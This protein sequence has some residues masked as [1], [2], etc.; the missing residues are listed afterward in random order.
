MTDRP[1]RG[2]WGL[3]L[4]P[5]AIVLFLLFVVPLAMLATFSFGT[6]DVLGRPELGFSLDNYEQVVQGYNLEVVARTVLYAASATAICLVMGYAVAYTAARFGGRWSVLLVAL[7]V[8]PWL[9]SYVVRIYAWKQLLGD[10]G[11]VNGGLT[12]V[13][14]GPVGWIGTPYAVV[15]GLVYSY[16]PL[17]ILPLYAS[18]KD[19]DPALIDA[20][21]DLFGSPRKTFWFVT[22]PSTR[23]GVVGGC[24]LVFLPALGDFATAQF[25][26]G[27]QTT[28]VG[29]IVA[30]QFVASGQQTFGAAL[31]MGLV[32]MLVLTVL[33][34]SLL[35]RRRRGGL[36]DVT[37]AG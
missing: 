4:A 1:G 26:G 12:W 31:S 21:K 14:L 34:A 7:V 5:S 19:L 8:V 18:L 37:V 16:L 27:A 30:D 23:T 20:G 24:M 32:V 33:T 35:N 9:V 17:M 13:G 2:L 6:V 11:I 10:E 29:N 15:G 25:L 22:L 36:A 28:M 3:M